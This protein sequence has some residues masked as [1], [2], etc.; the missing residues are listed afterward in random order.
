MSYEIMRSINFGNALSY[1][2]KKVL[3]QKL[4]T[5]ILT[6]TCTG[7]KGKVVLCVAIYNT[8]AA[9]VQKGE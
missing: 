5:A 8:R 3:W 9:S 7:K 6:E 2:I 4:A 1:V